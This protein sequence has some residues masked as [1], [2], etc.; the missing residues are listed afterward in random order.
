MLRYQPLIKQ[1]QISQLFSINFQITCAKL[2]QIVVKLNYCKLSYERCLFRY[3]VV[4]LYVYFHILVLLIFRAR[5]RL[6]P[7]G[8]LIFSWEFSFKLSGKKQNTLIHLR[9]LSFSGDTLLHNVQAKIQQH[10][11]SCHSCTSVTG[12]YGHSCSLLQLPVRRPSPHSKLCSSLTP[13]SLMMF[14]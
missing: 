7:R 11:F 6:G 2:K 5:A 14:L 4:W 3:S 9:Q 13:L 10:Q 8:L 1:T 12:K